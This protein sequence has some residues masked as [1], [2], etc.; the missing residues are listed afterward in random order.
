MYKDA[1]R[2]EL[3]AILV[4][5]GYVGVFVSGMLY[6]Y[7]FTTPFAT[8]LLLIFGGEV[9]IFAGAILAGVGAVLSDLFI[10]EFIRKSFSDEI[11]TFSHEKLVKGIKKHIPT[12]L[13]RPLILLIAAL[14]FASPVPDELAVSLLATQKRLSA[15][16]FMMFSYI[17]NTIGILIIMYLGSLL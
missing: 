8:A 16:A 12:S 2:P 10:F 17:S 6:T 9:N 5:I 1:Q 15:K 14:L 11:S 4:S 7:G 3:H 13:Q